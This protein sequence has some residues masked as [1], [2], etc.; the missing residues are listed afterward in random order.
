[1]GSRVIDNKHSTEIGARI[2]LT[3]NPHTIVRT[4]FV[5]ST[6]VECLLSMSPTV[7][8]TR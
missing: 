7:I 8:H 5:D 6:S 3:V 1:M 2:A 4:R